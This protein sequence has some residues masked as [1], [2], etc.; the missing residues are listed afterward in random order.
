MCDCTNRSHILSSCRNMS[1][2]CYI[3]LEK[4]IVW[5]GPRLQR[6]FH[7]LRL[8]VHPRHRTMKHK[9]EE[10]E[11]AAE[12]TPTRIPDTTANQPRNEHHKLYFGARR[13]STFSRPACHFINRIVLTFLSTKC[14]T[15]QIE[16]IS[17]HHVAICH[18]HVTYC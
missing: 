11:M 4:R 14:V 12:I 7:V 8:V 17:C 5:I 3:L 16:V 9:M 15:V 18:I 2:T 10:T 13:V 1:R 6:T